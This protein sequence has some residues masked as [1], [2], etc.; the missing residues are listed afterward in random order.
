LQ[1][2]DFTRPSLSAIYTTASVEGAW[3]ALKVFERQDVD[4]SKLRVRTMS[5]LKRSS[6]TFGRVLGH[7][8]GIG[9]NVL[10]DYI[11]AQRQ[12]Y[13]PLYGWVLEHKVQGLVEQ[14]GTLSAKQPIVLLDYET[15]FNVQDATSPLSHAG[16]L[17]L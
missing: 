12:I 7:R 11:E 15:N 9:S 17:K 10:L 6:R 16:L 13:L 8:A 2:I 4:L 1:R 3:Q 14:I 5:G